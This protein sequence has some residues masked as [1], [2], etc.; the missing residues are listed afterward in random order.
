M[1]QSREKEMEKRFFLE[2]KRMG[3]VRADPYT[4]FIFLGTKKTLILGLSCMSQYIYTDRVVPQAECTDTTRVFN[5]EGVFH[6]LLCPTDPRGPPPV[7]RWV[8]V[9]TD[10]HWCLVHPA[11]VQRMRRPAGNV[12]EDSSPSPPAAWLS[13][14]HA[15]T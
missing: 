3:R 13:A 5:V 9:K 7:R 11:T 2:K 1:T 14:S 6:L 8:M 12:S 10:S 15:C 4:A